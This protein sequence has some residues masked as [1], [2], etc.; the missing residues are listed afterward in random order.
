MHSCSQRGNALFLILIAVALFAALSYAVTQSGRGSG[1]VS[2][3]TA[4]IAASRVVQYAG[5]VEQAV[6]RMGLVNGCGETQ[7]S[8]ENSEVAGYTNA[9][10]PADDSCHVFEPAGGGVVWQDPPAGANDGSDWFF[11][12]GIV[13]S[14][15]DGSNS[16]W[17]DENADLTMVL[18]NV[19]REVCA[20]VNRGLG[21]EG[22][23]VDEGDLTP[24]QF[25]GSYVKS[26]AITGI[27]S[28]SDCTMAP[29]TGLCGQ[30]TG[31]LQEETTSNYVVYHILLPRQQ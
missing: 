9:S 19:T 10:A 13:L 27:P 21:I 14:S 20:A 28:G 24:D 29:D 7:I 25:T 15:K 16:A 6:S 23:P 30:P 26:D 8:F 12:G 2:R 5:A 22:I 3:E 4:L 11:L 31:C 18:P 17:L 1:T